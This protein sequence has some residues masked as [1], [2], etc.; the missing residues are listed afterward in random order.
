MRCQ[1]NVL[2]FIPASSIIRTAQGCE[3]DHVGIVLR[4][5]VDP[6]EVHILHATI[7][8]IIVEK[9]SKLQ[10]RIGKGKFYEKFIFRKLGMTRREEDLARLNEFYDRV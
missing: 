3:F 10:K 9:F 4:L 8:G 2:S 1:W 5:S 6:N 7:N